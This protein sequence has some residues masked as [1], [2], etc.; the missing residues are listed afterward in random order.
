M[1]LNLFIGLAGIILCIPMSAFGQSKIE[2]AAEADLKAEVAFPFFEKHITGFEWEYG[3]GG[4]FY[5]EVFKDHQYS[6][7][8]DYSCTITAELA[9]DAFYT[10]GPPV[11]PG[12]IDEHYF[13]EAEVIATVMRQGDLWGDPDNCDFE[14]EIS[15]PLIL[16]VTDF[17][18]EGWI[19]FTFILGEL[20][21]PP[22]FVGPLLTEISP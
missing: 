14:E 1:R 21:G 3:E 15:L 16:E 20:D 4:E 6:W 5:S 18:S 2:A 7:M 9:E 10:A 13:Y 12:Q 17:T 8:C 11:N 22:C 19:D